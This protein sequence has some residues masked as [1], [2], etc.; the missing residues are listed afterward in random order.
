[1]KLTHLHKIGSEWKSLK[2]EASESAQLV[3]VFG[4]RLLLVN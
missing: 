1:M 4:D 3:L 2:N